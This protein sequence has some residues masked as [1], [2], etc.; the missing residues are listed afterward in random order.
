MRSERQMPRGVR[1][2]FE[3]PRLRTGSRTEREKPAGRVVGLKH[4]NVHNDP[5]VLQGCIP[6][7]VLRKASAVRQYAVVG[8][9]T[10][11]LLLYAHVLADLGGAPRWMVSYECLAIM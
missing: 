10:M 6:P 11:Q 4:K 7:T 3:R 1:S 8:E 2:D 5:C 9:V